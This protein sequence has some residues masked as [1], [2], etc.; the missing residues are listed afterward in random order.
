MPIG[1]IVGVRDFYGRPFLLGP[2][3]LEPRP[4]SEVLIDAALEVVRST[5]PTLEPLRIIDVGT[6]SGCLLTT[7]LS[8]LPNAT[9]TGVDLSSGAIEVAKKNAEILGVAD[10]ARFVVGNGLDNINE[11]FD[12]LVSNP[13]YLRTEE[14]AGLDVEVKLH[15]PPLALDGGV[16]GLDVYRLIGEKISQVVPYGWMLFEVGAGMAATV[17]HEIDRFSSDGHGYQWRMWQDLNGHQ[18]C[19]AARTLNDISR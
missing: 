2:A 3:I 15:D 17:C 13:P 16:D 19:V 8:E 4:D 18:R 5:W 11:T 14:L 12:L 7:L 9:G 6:G 1:R 10:R